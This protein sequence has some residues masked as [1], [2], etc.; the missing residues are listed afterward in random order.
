MIALQMGLLIIA[1]QVTAQQDTTL[2]YDTVTAD[3]S[4]SYLTPMQYAFMLHEDP[5]WLLKMNL[6]VATEQ[7]TGGLLKVSFEKKITTGISLNTILS[8]SNVSTFYKNERGGYNFGLEA[9]LETRWYYKTLKKQKAGET[10][11]ALSG[12]YL[13]LGAGYHDLNHDSD[14]DWTFTSSGYLSIFANWGLQRRFLQHGY[15]DFG[16]K[17]GYN[18]MRND[19]G[20]SYGFLS[21]YVDAGLAFTRDK[22]SLDYDKLCPVL[23]C[24]AADR[25]LLKI[26][27]VDIVSVSTIR[28]TNIISMT[29]NISA[30]HKVGD[31]PFSVNARLSSRLD[32][33]FAP[34]YDY[35]AYVFYPQVILE[36]RYY[37]NLQ[38]RI[39]TGKSGNGLSANYVALGAIYKGEYQILVSNGY[40][41]DLSTSFGGI[42]L[43]TGIQR[44]ISDHLYYDFNVGLGYGAEIRYDGIEG[45]KDHENK[46]IF[47]LGIA[48]GYRF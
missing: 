40:R 5:G 21:T 32:F 15:L 7:F 46:L 2:R 42:L 41:S 39:L 6:L 25:Y 30:E 13:A 4:V 17:G 44:V 14:P 24:H 34:K 10:I 35:N 48:I 45:T 23:R 31:S 8:A 20:L 43:G 28:H 47:N 12:T 3:N 29:P 9:A 36:G 33:V 38:R 11:S 19:Q 1:I 22:Q 26:N 16:V 27:L 18:S 37:Y